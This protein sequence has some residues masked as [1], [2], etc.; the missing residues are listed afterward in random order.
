MAQRS[1]LGTIGLI[2]EK[3]AVRHLEGQ[4]FKILDTNVTYKFGE[5]DIVAKKDG[6][7]HFIEVK[8]AD[9]SSI[10]QVALSERIG[11]SKQ[12]RIKKSVQRYVAEKDLYEN[13]LQI[14]AMLLKINRDSKVVKVKY[15]SRIM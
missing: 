8:A 5:I 4:G 12:L 10:M 13:E 3:L 1:Q 14:D 15:L 11:P 6:V 9:V 7:V 2:G